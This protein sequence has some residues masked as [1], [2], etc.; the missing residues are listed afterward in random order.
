[1]NARTRAPALGIMLVGHVSRG[2]LIAQVSR[3]RGPAFVRRPSEGGAR[4]SG[5][6]NQPRMVNTLSPQARGGSDRTLPSVAAAAR[7]LAFA[8]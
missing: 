5:L 7:S 1:M 3:D 4:R 6:A 2:N 8:S